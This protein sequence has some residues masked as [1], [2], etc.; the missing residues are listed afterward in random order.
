MRKSVVAGILAAVGGLVALVVV[1]L[2]DHGAPID[3][4]AL[5]HSADDA[6]AARASRDPGSDPEWRRELASRPLRSAPDVDPEAQDSRPVATAEED[7]LRVLVVEEATGFPVPGAEI[8]WRDEADLLAGQ[9]PPV[10]RLIAEFDQAPHRTTA[11]GRGIGWV[12]TSANLGIAARLGSLFGYR[13]FPSPPRGEIRVSIAPG[14][15]IAARVTNEAG[16]PVGGIPVLIDVQSRR[17]RGGANRTIRAISRGADGVAVSHHTSIGADGF[18]GERVEIKAQIE[19]MNATAKTVPLERLKEGP[20]ALVLGATGRVSVKL[21]GPDGRPFASEATVRLDATRPGKG[22]G[23]LA[24]RAVAAAAAADF[25]CVPIGVPISISSESPAFDSSAAGSAM[26][27]VPGEEQTV[28]LAFGRVRARVKGRALDGEGVTLSF[29]QLRCEILESPGVP[30]VPATVVVTDAVGEFSFPVDRRSVR[31]GCEL[32]IE[33]RGPS[34]TLEGFAVVA[35][36]RLSDG[37]E[38]SIGE[39]RLGRGEV[40][41]AGIVVDDL[42]SPVA[43]AAVFP[44]TLRTAMRGQAQPAPW[45]ARAPRDLTRTTTDAEGR[46][47][48]PPPAKVRG[49]MLAVTISA[50]L[51]GYTCAEPVT[52]RIGAKDVRV[53][54]SATGVLEGR[55]LLPEPAPV[56]KLSVLLTRPGSGPQQRQRHEDCVDSDGRFRIK[57]LLPGTVTVAVLFAGTTD[58]LVSLGEI[59]IPRLGATGDSRLAEIDLR[60]HA[61]LRR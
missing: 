54:L 27:S 40:L 49:A 2:W 19:G 23:T 11:D 8:A 47:E 36:P 37:D 3:R 42:G 56:R 4:P 34:G 31:A 5:A 38:T 29:R 52:A 7:A 14:F 15:F 13:V 51:P 61:V 58:P 32:E 35:M 55:L 41:A 60:D 1:F 53:V 10:S 33:H 48:L 57:A 39:V 16:A 43:G 25:P 6:P 44:A 59:A 18:T 24:L 20:I 17:G 22:G 28:E 12:R 21:K 30:G 45:R 9:V 50:E 26:L 46:F